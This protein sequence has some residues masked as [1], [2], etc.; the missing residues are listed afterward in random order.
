M[1]YQTTYNGKEKELQILLDG[2]RIVA[3]SEELEFDIHHAGEDRYLI[4]LGSRTYKVDE[5]Q[6]EGEQVSFRYNGVPI[7][8]Q[9]RNK[10]ELLLELLGMKREEAAREEALR[11]P[12]P[13]R[14]LQLQVE[15]EQ[16][17]KK[18][19]PVAT[20][21]AMKMENQIKA[22]VDGRIK[23]IL[24]NKNQNVEKND[25]LMEIEASG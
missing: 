7:T 12:M 14:I 23:K 25:V 2:N 4:K 18:G 15:Q 10:Q 17:V 13:G 16:T 6:L 9:V 19:Q 3:G 22:P 11:A 20:L 21:E 5:V 1:N 8:V 24:I